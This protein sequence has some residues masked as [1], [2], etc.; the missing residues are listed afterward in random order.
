M[1][2]DYERQY[3]PDPSIYIVSGH[4]PTEAVTGKQEIYKTHNN[5]LIDCGATFGGKLAC[6]CLNT[7][8]EYYV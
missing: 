5:I 4:T 3:Y 2:P 6:L 1:R 7:M 8:E